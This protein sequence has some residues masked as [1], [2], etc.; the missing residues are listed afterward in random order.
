MSDF[1]V[2]L[3]NFFIYGKEEGIIEEITPCIDYTTGKVYD[4][5][6]FL[7]LSKNVVVGNK[8]FKKYKKIIVTT[9][10]IKKFKVGD[11]YCNE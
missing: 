9:N 1:L 3:K 4:E 6:Q 5:L 11:Y 2:N 10:E 7:L 8:K